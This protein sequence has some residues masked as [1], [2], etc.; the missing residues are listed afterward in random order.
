[1]GGNGNFAACTT[2]QVASGT[3]DLKTNYTI[4]SG[5]DASSLQVAT[6]S[7]ANGIVCYVDLNTELDNVN[8]Q[9]GPATCKIPSVDGGELS[10]GP[11]N[12][13]NDL[14]E[15]FSL[16]G[17]SAQATSLCYSDDGAGG[18]ACVSLNMAET[19]TTHTS[20]ETHTST[21]TMTVSETAGT[22]QTSGTSSTTATTDTSTTSPHT[23]TVTETTTSPHTTTIT[24]VTETETT[25]STTIERELNGGAHGRLRLR[26][27]RNGGGVR[28][29]GRLRDSGGV[30]GG[31]G[32]IR[33][34]GSAASAA[35]LCGTSRFTYSHCAGACMSFRR[36]V[37]RG[38]LGHVERHTSSAPS[39][40][41]RVAQ[42]GGLRGE[43]NEREILSLIVDHIRRP[44]R[45][46]TAVD[47]QYLARGRTSLAIYVVQLCVEVD[48][49][50]DSIRITEG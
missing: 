43:T 33:R 20:T 26:N 40:V 5:S 32:C 16:V 4:V 2:Y 1:M 25:V 29:G 36:G 34:G 49:A 23:T 14:T 19:T 28:R 9:A 10:F 12:V 18:A 30:R 15:Y 13:V 35:S 47:A 11:P 24:S 7:D 21:S 41:V 27:T 17:L 48:V 6:L 46:P 45:E 3:L 31:R 39:S 50:D 42:R 38:G 37:G 22:T 8:G 44:K